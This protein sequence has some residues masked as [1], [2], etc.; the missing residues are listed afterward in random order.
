MYNIFSI[1]LFL[2]KLINGL[3]ELIS[4]RVISGIRWINANVSQRYDTTSHKQWM[5]KFCLPLILLISI[6]I[7][8][9]FFFGLYSNKNSL[10]RRRVRLNWGYLYNEYKVQV[11]FWELIKIIQ[12]E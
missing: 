4:Y 9:Y 11:Y 2:T 6:L 1:H 7:P 5:F 8:C 3:I 10:E 12:K